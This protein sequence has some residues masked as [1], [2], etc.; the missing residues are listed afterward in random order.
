MN[1]KIRDQML[2]QR[3]IRG[4]I[5]R[6]GQILFERIPSHPHHRQAGEYK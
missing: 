5:F 1:T 2:R 4:A 3:R 6:V